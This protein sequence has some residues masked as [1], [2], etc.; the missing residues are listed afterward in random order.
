MT[1]PAA[2]FIADLAE[3]LD[4]SFAALLAA[5]YDRRFTGTVTLHFQ[6]GQPRAVDFPQPIRV[7]FAPAGSGG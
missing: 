7:T 3:T 4:V 5:I 6:R 1:D 2:D